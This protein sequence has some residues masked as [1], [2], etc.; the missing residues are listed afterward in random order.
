MFMSHIGKLDV[1]TVSHCWFN[2]IGKPQTLNIGSHRR[3]SAGSCGRIEGGSQKW[4]KIGGG[5]RE[6]KRR[7][8]LMH[9][10]LF[11]CGFL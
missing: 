6:M 10:A 8:L 4:K 2:N 7:L 11:L 9:V 3:I 1:S 5:S